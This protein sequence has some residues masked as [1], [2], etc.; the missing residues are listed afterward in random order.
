[1]HHI[2][3]RFLLQSPYEAEKHTRGLCIF[4]LVKASIT[5]PPLS[6][7]TPPNPH[8]SF[9]GNDGVNDKTHQRAG[10]GEARREKGNEGESA[11][12]LII[13]NFNPTIHTLT[14][15]RIGVICVHCVVWRVSE[16]G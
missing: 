16:L 9:R 10:R 8:P 6:H 1:M 14:L 15:S 3:I 13:A 7:L 4:E 5:I 2:L 11:G 12:T